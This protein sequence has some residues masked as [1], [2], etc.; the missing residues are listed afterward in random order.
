MVAPLAAAFGATKSA[1]EIAAAEINKRYEAY[2]ETRHAKRRKR[3][4]TKAIDAMHDSA[5]EMHTCII[6]RTPRTCFGDS[7][8]FCARRCA[9]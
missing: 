4:E 3:L 8:Q 2:E 5:Y 1:T 7:L 9:N 6:T